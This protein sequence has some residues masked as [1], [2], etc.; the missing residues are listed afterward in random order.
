MSVPVIQEADVMTSGL[1]SDFDGF[2]RS[3][4]ARVLGLVY[5]LSGSSWGAEDIAQDAF[6]KAHRDWDRIGRL[7]RPDAYV[8]TIAINLARSRVRRAAAELRALRRLVGAT[9]SSFPVL[10]PE[11]DEFWS[12]VRTLPR[13]Q[14]EVVALHYG[15]DLAVAD[16]AH[17]LGVS[18]STVKT[19]L[20]K[21]RASL[22]RYFEEREVMS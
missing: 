11:S 20:Q 1:V 21:G 8:R 3:E 6:L 13:R 9:S 5:A 17:I 16:I 19:S 14:S 4:W 12:M 15:D 10:E 7:E 22:A 18:E 2:Y